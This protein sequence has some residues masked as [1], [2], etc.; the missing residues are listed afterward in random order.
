MCFSC[1]NWPWGQ[2]THLAAPPTRDIYVNLPDIYGWWP[3]S[4]AQ[5]SEESS[6][7]EILV[8][9]PG[10][11][12]LVTAPLDLDCAPPYLSLPISS[13]HLHIT[14]PARPKQ[15]IAYPVMVLPY[16]DYLSLTHNVRNDPGAGHMER[17]E[18]YPKTLTYIPA[19][20]FRLQASA[21]TSTY[22]ANLPNPQA[23]YYWPVS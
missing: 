13:H 18:D 7:L 9:C 4:T 10:A 19:H 12:L 2:A 15:R 3:D 6:F 23:T 21:P 8:T 5:V 22:Y 1:G 17:V 20:D 16:Y 11:L 14:T